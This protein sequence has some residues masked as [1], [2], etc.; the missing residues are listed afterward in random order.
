MEINTE[1]VA[2][3]ALTNSWKHRVYNRVT[4][5]L[6]IRCCKG[7]VFVTEELS[8]SR[9]F[10][11]LRGLKITIP[12]GIDLRKHHSLGPSASTKPRIIYLGSDQPSQGIEIIITLAREIPELSFDIVGPLA[13]RLGDCPRNVTA[14]GYLPQTR[15]RPI[16]ERADLGLGCLALHLKGLNEACPL[17]TREYL[18]AG[19]PVIV[20]YT[21]SDFPQ[22]APFMLNLKA[23]EQNVRCNVQPII[24]FARYWH[25]RR[26]PR[27]DVSCIGVGEKERRRLAFLE[28]I[29]RHEA[30]HL[31]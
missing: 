12:N 27:P 4:R 13:E 3:F 14:H 5:W 17:K 19:L 29:L 25:G 16:M 20:G 22:G 2:E 15:Y 23:P 28:Q 6:T 9:R 7:M 30:Q 11:G 18:A 26:V 1:D 31:V 24:D 8:R 21:D 10:N